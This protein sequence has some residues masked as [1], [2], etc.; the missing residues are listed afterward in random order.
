MRQMGFVAIRTPYTTW[1]WLEI[2][3]KALSFLHASGE[4][5]QEPTAARR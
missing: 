3:E 2:D 1:Y 5:F 4:R